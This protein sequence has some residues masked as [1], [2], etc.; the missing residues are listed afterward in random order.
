MSTTKSLRS[1]ANSASATI[2]MSVKDLEE[3]IERA[4]A[5]QSEELKSTIASLKHEVNSLKLTVE[6]LV[7]VNSVAV[8]DSRSETQLFDESC[9]SIETVVSQAEKTTGGRN[10]NSR[11]VKSNKQRTQIIRGTI[12][13][14][15]DNQLT[16]SAA[17]RRAWIYV[18]RVDQNTKSEQISKYLHN[19]FPSNTFQIEQLPKREDAT[20][21][22]FKIGADVSLMDELYNGQMWP[23]GVIVK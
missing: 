22:S 16:F 20:S 3:I 1:A 19:K 6:S 5:K 15:T 10:K 18:G 17:I 12:T 21:I 9:E 14:N 8:K 23:A 4:L 13:E 7:K 11:V 2:T